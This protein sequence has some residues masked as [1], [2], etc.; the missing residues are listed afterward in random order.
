MAARGPYILTT[1][2]DVITTGL[3]VLAIIWE[4]ATSAGDTALILDR[5]SNAVLWAGRTDASNTY[6]G[7]NFGP[8]GIPCPDGVRLSQISGGRVFVYPR[9]S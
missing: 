4:G 7:A 2:G 6:L 1:A 5:G 9:E 8:E 3:R